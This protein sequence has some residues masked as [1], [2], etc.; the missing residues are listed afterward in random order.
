MLVLGVKETNCIKMKMPLLN[1]GGDLKHQLPD[2]Y[3]AL[4][5]PLINELQLEACDHNSPHERGWGSGAPLNIHISGGTD[6]FKISFES[7]L[8]TYSTINII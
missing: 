4:L 5:Q 8:L 1:N 2:T 3:N 7:V 6:V